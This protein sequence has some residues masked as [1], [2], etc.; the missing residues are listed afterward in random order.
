MAAED[1]GD[2]NGILY[3][4]GGLVGLNCCILTVLGNQVAK[5]RNIEMGIPTSAV[6]SFFDC[7]TCYSCSV[8]AEAKGIKNEASG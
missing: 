4:L 3:L 7:C 2:S 5:K 1:I 8:V 6:C